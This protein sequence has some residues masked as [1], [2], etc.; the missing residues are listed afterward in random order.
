MTFFS[1]PKD[2]RL[3]IPKLLEL[4][5]GAPCTL[6]VPEI[7][8][9]DVATTVAAHSNMSRHG[10]GSFL[11]SHD[12]FVAFGC[13]ACHYWLDFGKANRA[14]KEEIF[15]RGME[16]TWFWLWFEGKIKVA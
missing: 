15:I 12:P 11:K 7:C 8:T 3:E 16:R 6:L 5:N 2:K 4:A 9:G 10:R 1:L 14:D 13:S